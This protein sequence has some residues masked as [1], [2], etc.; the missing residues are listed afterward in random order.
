MTEENKYRIIA[1]L[2]REGVFDLCGGE[3]VYVRPE[4]PAELYGLEKGDRI[5][6][7]NGEPLSHYLLFEKKS[8]EEK[9]VI[10][11]LKKTEKRELFII[12]KEEGEPLGVQLL[13]YIYDGLKLC[14]NHCLFCFV[15]QQPPKMRKTLSYKDDDYRFSFYQGSYITMT[16]LKKRDGLEIAREDLSPLYISIHTTN[17]ELRVKMLGHKNASTI[18]EQLSFLND[19]GISFHGQLVLC[20]GINDGEELVRTLN[21]LESFYPSL[22]SLSLIPVGLTSFREGLYPL[23]SYTQK[24]ADEIIDLT[25][26][27]QREYKRR[28]GYNC[29]YVADEFFLLAGREVMDVEEYDGFPQYENG[30]GMIASFYEEVSTLLESGLSLPRGEYSFI[31]SV[32]GAE[33]LK[34]F[35]EKMEDHGLNLRPIVVENRTF[36]SCVTVTG[37]LTGRDILRELKARCPKSPVFLPGHLLNGEDLFLDDMSLHHLVEECQ[38]PIIVSPPSGEGF[39]KTLSQEVC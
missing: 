18:L 5:L 33:A 6:S 9:L 12:D 36:G 16:N 39:L 2:M 21:D 37:L 11:I 38:A 8:S 3:I 27:R 7:L 31:T 15:D 29:I 22:L 35:V 14:K 24:E 20:P 23:R 34:L 30:V 1:V 13:G 19:K 17:P 25:L 26:E 28:F 10:E 32:L 4:S